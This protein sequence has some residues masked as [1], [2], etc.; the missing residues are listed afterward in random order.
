LNFI[1]KFRNYF[2]QLH[3]KKYMKSHT[4][5][6]ISDYKTMPDTILVV[7]NTALGDTILSTSAIKSIKH[8]FPNTKIIFLVKK[9]LVNLFYNFKYV[10]EIIPFYEGYKNYFKT[11][12]NIKIH[13]PKMSI[14]FHGNG[15]QDIQISILSGCQFIFKHP[16]KSNFKEHL[17][18][19]FKLKNQ[20]TIDDRLDILKKLNAKKLFT[21]IE[22]P[23]QDKKHDINVTKLLKNKNKIIGFQI[24]AADTYKMW[25]INNFIALAKKIIKFDP[26]IT[27]VIT[28]IKEE[29]YLAEKI[30]IESNSNIINSCGIFNIN[31][32]TYLIKKMNMLITNDTGTMHM[33]IALDVSTIALFSTTDSIKSGPHPDVL[34]H[35]YLIQKNGLAVQS[36]PKKKRTNELMNLI[37][38]D[39]VFEIAKRVISKC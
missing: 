36:L 13:N 8:S 6:M 35:H 19:N 37:E 18:Y 16:T 2:Y 28:G 29:F 27:I 23:E 34:K 3:V 17:S 7:S 14:I 24:G 31:E 12:K 22:L 5:K 38:V 1:R 11:I 9:N 10:D 21:K 30:V 39:E 4:V 32:L 25:P 20:H 33:A 15:P 26:N